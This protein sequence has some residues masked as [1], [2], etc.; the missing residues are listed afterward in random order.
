MTNGLAS[1]LIKSYDDT[2]GTLT[3]L[4][5]RFV[6]LALALGAVALALGIVALLTSLAPS[7]GKWQILTPQ[8]AKTPEPILSWHS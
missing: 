8:G 1:Y 5:L 2:D 3:N 4:A 7:I 6:A